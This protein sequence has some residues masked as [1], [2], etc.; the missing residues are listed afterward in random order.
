MKID[1]TKAGIRIRWGTK[2]VPDL[3]TEGKSSTAIKTYHRHYV[4]QRLAGDAWL[5]PGH[6]LLREVIPPKVRG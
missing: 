4:Y 3:T 5:L 6:Y 2:R 1:H